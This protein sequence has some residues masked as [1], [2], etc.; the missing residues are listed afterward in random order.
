MDFFMLQDVFRSY[1][2][3]LP[4]VSSPNESP[5]TIMPSLSMFVCLSII[6]LSIYLT[7]FLFFSFL[8][9]SLSLSFIYLSTYLLTFLHI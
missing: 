2:L 8:S 4:H 6:Y 3:P 9:L 1:T 5:C 7:V